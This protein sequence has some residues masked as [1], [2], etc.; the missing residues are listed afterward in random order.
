MQLDKSNML[1]ESLPRFERC[2]TND[3]SQKYKQDTDDS[4]SL[5]A[6]CAVVVTMMSSMG[7]EGSMA[8][9]TAW[10]GG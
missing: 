10:D 4:T 5:L 1:V 6:F 3:C 7:V 2:R 9:G 8:F